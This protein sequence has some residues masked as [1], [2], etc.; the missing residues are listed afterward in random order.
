MANGRNGSWGYLSSFPIP[1]DT[2]V[3]ARRQSFYSFLK[4][5][6]FPLKILDFPLSKYLSQCFCVPIFFPRILPTACS[7]G[8]PQL[9][10]WEIGE[11][12]CELFKALAPRWALWISFLSQKTCMWL[13]RY[14]LTILIYWKWLE[15]QFISCSSLSNTNSSVIYV[16]GSRWCVSQRTLRRSL[17][18]SVHFLRAKL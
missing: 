6:G 16:G 14:E 4:W 15:A 3:M 10:V 13:R 8:W 7:N 1:Q 2:L 5:V 9:V 12:K 11:W 18:H 17:T